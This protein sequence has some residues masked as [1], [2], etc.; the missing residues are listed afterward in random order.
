MPRFSLPSEA[1]TRKAERNEQNPAATYGVYTLACNAIDRRERAVPAEKARIARSFLVIGASHGPRCVRTLASAMWTSA[2]A[3]R[4]PSGHEKRD[5]YGD[6]RRALSR[7][8]CTH[9]P[10]RVVLIHRGRRDRHEQPV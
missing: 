8:R 7:D 4:L 2:F 9:A 6:A 5:A 3:L 10:R 1:K